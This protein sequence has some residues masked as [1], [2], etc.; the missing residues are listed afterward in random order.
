ME[1]ARLFLFDAELDQDYVEFTKQNSLGWVYDNAVETGPFSNA[2]LVAVRQ[3]THEI[4]KTLIPDYSEKKLLNT[5]NST[6]FGEIH[7]SEGFMPGRIVNIP[8]IPPV[9]QIRRK[10]PCPCGS[11]KKYKKCHGS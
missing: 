3:I 10:G 9:T 1:T 4:L 7:V 6:V 11:G 2:S 5:H 8:S